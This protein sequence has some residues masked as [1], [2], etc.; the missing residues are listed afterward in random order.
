MVGEEASSFNFLNGF[1]FFIARHIQGPCMVK[2]LNTKQNAASST[3]SKVHD[4]VSSDV[5]GDDDEDE[6]E[7]QNMHAQIKEL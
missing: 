6:D 1:E 3:L 2:L 5:D 7:E 4:V